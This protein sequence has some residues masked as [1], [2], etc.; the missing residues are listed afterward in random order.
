MGWMDGRLSRSIR[1]L[2][3]PNGANKERGN[4]TQVSDFK[5]TGV[6]GKFSTILQKWRQ[7][8]R[9]P[10]YKRPLNL[11]LKQYTIQFEKQNPTL[12][13]D[14][15]KGNIFKQTDNV[16]IVEQTGKGA[17]AKEQ[18]LVKSWQTVRESI[19]DKLQENG[20]PSSP[21]LPKLPKNSH[22]ETKLSSDI[23]LESGKIKSSKVLP[24]QLTSVQNLL[25]GK[26]N[27]VRGDQGG[28]RSEAKRAT[29]RLPPARASRR[30]P[31]PARPSS[32]AL[33]IISSSSKPSTQSLPVSAEEIAAYLLANCPATRLRHIRRICTAFGV[34]QR[35]SRKGEAVENQQGSKIEDSKKVTKV[36]PRRRK[37]LGVLKHKQRERQLSSLLSRVME[38]VNAPFRDIFSFAR[39]RF[40]RDMSPK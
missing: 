18:F 23:R 7:H 26:M 11:G 31:A 28:L 4:I 25:R 24:S 33:P 39:R 13:A 27:P 30:P 37:R 6:R 14:F 21:S 8:N 17:S 35:K 9:Q 1:L 29:T 16:A 40:G 5:K 2:R 22:D 32:S 19:K 10:F 38:I 20:N 34:G 36:R 3:A 12:P 15:L